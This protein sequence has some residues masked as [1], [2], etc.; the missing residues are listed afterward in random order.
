MFPSDRRKGT[1]GELSIFHEKTHDE[2]EGRMMSACKRGDAQKDGLR[3][4]R[5]ESAS[6]TCTEGKKLEEILGHQRKE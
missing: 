6:W 2:I 4:Q 3:G 5:K 1:G